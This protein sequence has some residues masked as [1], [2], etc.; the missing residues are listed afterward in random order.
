MAKSGKNAK[1][2]KN[3]VIGKAPKTRGNPEDYLQLTPAWRISK[4]HFKDPYGWHV[5]TIDDARTIH[6]KLL[7]LESMTWQEILVKGRK[8]YHLIEKTQLCSSAQAHLEEMAIDDIDELLSL[9][10]SGTERIWGILDRGIV[11]LLWWDPNHEIC[12]SP[13]KHT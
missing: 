4:L 10:L 3:P 2:A 9:R 11:Q 8:H 1:A 5:L 12:P 6:Q 13:L 7:H